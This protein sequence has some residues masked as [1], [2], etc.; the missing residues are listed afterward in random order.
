MRILVADDDPLALRLAERLLVSLGH[1]VETASDG[2][3][4]IRLAE[5]GAPDFIL[6]D[7][8]MP[9]CDGI[10][11]CGRLRAALPATRFALMTGSPASAEAAAKAGF[12]FVLLKP[13]E[14]GELKLA[15][16]A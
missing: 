5:A 3:A 10:S 2:E 13:L 14:P 9:R 7:V 6:S 8:D 11:A 4:L 16:R 1:A 15:L 12:A